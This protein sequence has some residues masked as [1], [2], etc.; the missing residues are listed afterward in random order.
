MTGLWQV[1][2]RCALGVEEALALDVQYVERRST[3]LDLRILLRTP[4]AVLTGRGAY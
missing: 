1:S 3:L 2:G 4:A